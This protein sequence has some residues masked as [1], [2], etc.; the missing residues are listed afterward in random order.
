MVI[1]KRKQELS[2]AKFYE[3]TQNDEETKDGSRRRGKR[4]KKGTIFIKV[5][6]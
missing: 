5:R 3:N 6:H 2:L 4:G 1:K